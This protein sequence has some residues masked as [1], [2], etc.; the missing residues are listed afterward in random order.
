MARKGRNGVGPG[1][2]RSGIALLTI[3][4]SALLGYALLTLV[5]RTNPSMESDRRATLRL[6]RADHPVLERAMSAVSWV[7]FRPQ[8]LLLPFAAIS[9]TWLLRMRRESLLLVAAWGASMV[10]FLTKL[11]VQRPRPDLPEIRVIAANIR[12]TSFPS[13]HTIHYVVFWGFF[14]YLVLTRVRSNVA[15]ALTVAVTAPLI[16]LVGPSRVYLG[17]HWLT[18]VLGSYLLGTAYVLGL[19]AIDRRV[20]RCSDEDGTVSGP[21]LPDRT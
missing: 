9:G 11:V 18:D 20:T 12:D 2:Q 19:V 17:H 4:L 1:R 21:A 3:S 16:A 10:S 5:V 14:T 6:Q 8:S 13:G 7:G 15:R